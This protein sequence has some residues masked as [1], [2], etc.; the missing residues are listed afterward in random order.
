MYVYKSN[1]KLYCFHIYEMQ[2]IVFKVLNV[3]IL[4][5]CTLN[6]EHVLITYTFVLLHILKTYCL[7]AAKMPCTM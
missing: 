2:L 5:T 3:L 6:H 7:H 4:Y 1:L